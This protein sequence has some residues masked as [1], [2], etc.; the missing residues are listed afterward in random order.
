MRNR[1]ISQSLRDVASFQK[2]ELII[3][4]RQIE[5]LCVCVWGGD[6]KTIVKLHG[7][8]I[9]I[10]TCNLMKTQRIFSISQ[11]ET[12]LLANQSDHFKNVNF[13]FYKHCIYTVYFNLNKCYLVFEIT[14]IFQLT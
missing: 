1:N 11:M 13:I 7:L 14:F 6:T 8:L 12:L 9:Y 5:N 2:P 4:L 10:V 3:C